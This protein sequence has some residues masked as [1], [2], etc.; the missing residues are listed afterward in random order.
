MTSQTITVAQARND[1]SN[2]LDQVELLRRRFV[3]ASRG[4]PKA[5]LVSVEDLARLE[6]LER[7]AVAISERDR[8]IQVLEEAGM[9]RPLSPELFQKYVHLSPVE[10]ERARQEL[11]SLRFD[12]P[13][14]EMIIQDRGER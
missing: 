3:I 10:R 9:I 6:A 7:P 11:A 2:L 12:P 8:A 4:K 1:F 14:S 13:A 5:V